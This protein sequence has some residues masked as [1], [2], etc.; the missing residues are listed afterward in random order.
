MDGEL[1]EDVVSLSRQFNRNLIYAH[2]AG[3]WVGNVTRVRG[4]AKGEFRMSMPM[5]TR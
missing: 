1:S 2:S 5:T 4:L 3:A